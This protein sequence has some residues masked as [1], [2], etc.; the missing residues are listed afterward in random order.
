MFKVDNIPQNGSFV[1]GTFVAPYIFE[2]KMKMQSFFSYIGS[3]NYLVWLLINITFTA[4]IAAA[5]SFTKWPTKLQAGI[6]VNISFVI[7]V[8]ATCLPLV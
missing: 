1:E 4:F 7:G 5:M 6:L 2:R 3:W 8:L